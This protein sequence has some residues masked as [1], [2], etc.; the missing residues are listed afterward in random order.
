MGH[1]IQEYLKKI[2]SRL[3]FYDAVSAAITALFLVFSALYLF[4]LF[5]SKQVPV[6]YRTETAKD[7]AQQPDSRPFGSRNGATYTYSWCGGS[8]RIKLENKIFF[9]NATFAE[10]SGRSL[11]KLCQK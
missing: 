7:N 9:E 1:S 3:S 11:S 6:V 4:W 8:D 5:Y 10:R 2:N